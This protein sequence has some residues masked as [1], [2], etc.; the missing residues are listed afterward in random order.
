MKLADWLDLKGWTQTKL[1]EKLEL[2][3]PRT[4]NR[5]VRRERLPTPEMQRKIAKTTDNA[6]TPN[7]WVLT[8]QPLEAAE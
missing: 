6:V 2:S 1:A 3:D 4:I 8:S 7:D 5:Y